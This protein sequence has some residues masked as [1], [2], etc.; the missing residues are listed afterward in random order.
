MTHSLYQP[1]VLLSV[2]QLE[3]YAA[4]PFKQFSDRLLALRERPE[5]Q[6][7]RTLTGVLLHGMMEQALRTVCYELKW[8]DAP[9]AFWQLWIDRD[10][11]ARSGTDSIERLTAIG[12]IDS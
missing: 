11:T 7:E 2:S 3:I 10:L 12:C 4:C 8:P 9:N 5:W 6:P 1:P